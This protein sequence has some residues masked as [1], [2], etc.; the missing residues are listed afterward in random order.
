MAQ[1]LI[2][3]LPERMKDPAELLLLS[4]VGAGAATMLGS[5]GLDGAI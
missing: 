2:C 1:L 5:G 4:G 3:F